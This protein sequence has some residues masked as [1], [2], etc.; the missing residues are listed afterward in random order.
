MMPTPTTPDVS[1][2]NL[3]LDTK[4]KEQ[5][6]ATL[7]ELG[8]T[9]SEAIRDYFE[10]VVEAKKLPFKRQVISH[11]DAELLAIAKERLRTL[12]DEDVIRGITPDELFAQHPSNRSK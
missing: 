12:K 2:I 1:Q 10:H 4:L 7:K 11:E 3:R 9:P 5:I 8:T 6:Y